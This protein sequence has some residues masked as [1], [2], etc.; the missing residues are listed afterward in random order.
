MIG[1]QSS[2]PGSRIDLHVAD[3]IVR[4][5]VV[6]RSLLIGLRNGMQIL[7][8]RGLVGDPVVH[9]IQQVQTAK[10]AQAPLRPVDAHP[11]R[12]PIPR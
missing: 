8:R 6:P 7:G 2:D 5:E 3:R 4:V 11:Q 1:L 12:Q 9:V 10:L